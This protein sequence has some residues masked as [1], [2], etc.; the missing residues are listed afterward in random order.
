MCPELNFTQDISMSEKSDHHILNFKSD[1]SYSDS[2][3]VR[4]KREVD[5]VILG[6]IT[7]IPEFIESSLSKPISLRAFVQFD[8]QFTEKVNDIFV[9]LRWNQP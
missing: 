2:M 9:T 6:N 5:E 1:R 4:N 7:I 3:T 8:S